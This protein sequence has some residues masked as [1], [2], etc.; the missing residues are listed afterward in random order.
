MEVQVVKNRLSVS[1]IINDKPVEI[2]LLEINNYQQVDLF[3]CILRPIRKYILDHLDY[4]EI[5]Q[6]AK[7]LIDL[8]WNME[9][10]P[11]KNEEL[12]DLSTYLYKYYINIDKEFYCLKFELKDMATK[13]T[14]DRAF[15][16]KVTEMLSQAIIFPVKKKIEDIKY[17]RL[18]E[19]IK[20]ACTPL[21]AD[22]WD[23][24]KL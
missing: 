16:D 8:Y 18:E 3:D 24:I 13:Q 6:G 10:S 23:N 19:T 1:L 2:E 14:V 11:F 7:T 22:V 20:C 12:S 9:S 17:T 15:Y 21:L 5:Y 4:K